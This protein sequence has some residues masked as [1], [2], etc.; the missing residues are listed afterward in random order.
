MMK[1]ALTI[2]VAVLLLC[3]LCPHSSAAPALSGAA[4]NA[5][6]QLSSDQI[7]FFMKFSLELPSYVMIGGHKFKLNVGM[8]SA[9]PP[10]TV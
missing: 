6:C 2:T 10:P 3:C 1:T 7:D 4:G 8:P 5:S 9:T